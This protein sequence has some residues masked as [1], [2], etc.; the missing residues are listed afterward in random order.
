MTSSGY[1]ITSWEIRKKKIFYTKTCHSISYTGIC[2]YKIPTFKIWMLNS[3]HSV[4]IL[5]KEIVSKGICFRKSMSMAHCTHT[6]Q[7]A[8]YSRLYAFFNK[9]TLKYHKRD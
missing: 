1:K 5:S 2:P 8:L 4:D 7:F 6:Q 9:Y 3:L